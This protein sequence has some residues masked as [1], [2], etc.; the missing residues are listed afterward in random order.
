MSQFIHKFSRKHTM[1]KTRHSGRGRSKIG[2]CNGNGQITPACLPHY[3]PHSSCNKNV[4]STHYIM[5]LQE[6]RWVTPPPYS[7]EPHEEET[8]EEYKS[9]PFSLQL[10]LAAT[11]QQGSQR[12]VPR[13]A[14]YKA[15]TQCYTLKLWGNFL[16]IIFKG[17]L[18]LRNESA[19]E[20]KTATY[21]G[22][23]F[24][25]L[26]RHLIQNTTLWA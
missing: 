5:G 17:I 24:S 8:R 4:L 2:K 1:Q 14:L 3:L 6:E 25:H 16:S 22:Q 21:I 7:Q 10:L 9:S 13:P 20:Y 15:P 26:F 12:A 11:Q 18:S 19:Q 23:I